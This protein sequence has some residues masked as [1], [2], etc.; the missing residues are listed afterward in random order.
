MERREEAW[1]RGSAAAVDEILHDMN[2]LAARRMMVVRPRTVEYAQLYSCTVPWYSRNLY[3]IIE[4]TK[5]PYRPYPIYTA[6]VYSVRYRGLK[7]IRYIQGL[8]LPTLQYLP[9]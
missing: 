3:R 5:V 9:G 6:V 2:M 1:G 8:S 4:Y 7:I